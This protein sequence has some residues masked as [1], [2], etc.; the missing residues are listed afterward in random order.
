MDILWE[1]VDKLQE[2]VVNAVVAT[3]LV[4]TLDRVE[5]VERV[6]RY[7]LERYLALLVSLHKLTVEA[8]RCATRCESEHKWRELLV[9][10]T[11]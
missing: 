5:L 3:L 2:L 10:V 1:D 11:C 9:Y 7:V 8:Q 4:G 6:Y